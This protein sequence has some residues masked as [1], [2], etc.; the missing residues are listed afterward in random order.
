MMITDGEDDDAALF[1]NERARCMHGLTSA[2]LHQTLPPTHISHDDEDDGGHAHDDT[3]TSPMH[4]DDENDDDDDNYA[5]DGEDDDTSRRRASKP[6]KCMQA[7]ADHLNH[8]SVH[9]AAP[10]VA[11]AEAEVSPRRRPVWGRETRIH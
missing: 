5:D 7:R 10:A 11:P 6:C 1:T 3:K 4:A 8:P 9:V 2:P